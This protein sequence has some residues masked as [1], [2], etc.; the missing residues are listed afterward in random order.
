MFLLDG[1]FHV[2]V[3]TPGTLRCIGGRM[4]DISV[5]LIVVLFICY[6]LVTSPIEFQLILSCLKKKKIQ[7]EGY[8]LSLN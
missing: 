5:L 7:G 2:T 8:M 1:H 4:I 3:T 6:L